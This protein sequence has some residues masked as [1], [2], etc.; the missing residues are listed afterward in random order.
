MT[1]QQREAKK[2]PLP[3]TFCEEKGLIVEVPGI[4]GYSIL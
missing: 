1:L 3:L 2:E 4:D